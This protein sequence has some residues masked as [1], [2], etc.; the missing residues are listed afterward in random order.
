[1][2]SIKADIQLLR[3]KWEWDTVSEQIKQHNISDTTTT[4]CQTQSN[5]E[6]LKGEQ[7]NLTNIY[8]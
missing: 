2:N 1:M 4:K 6:F 7:W 5:M 3:R 8:T